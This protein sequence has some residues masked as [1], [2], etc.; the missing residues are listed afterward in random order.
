MKIEMYMIHDKVSGTYHL[1][2]LYFHNDEEA[3]RGFGEM[4]KAAGSEFSKHPGDIE[5]LHI[6]A[7][8]IENGETTIEKY[9][10]KDGNEIDL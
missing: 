3:K 4:I 2:H 9:K 5:M 8:D 6:G 10:V 7:V 1:P